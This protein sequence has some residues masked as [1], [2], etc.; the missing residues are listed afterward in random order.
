MQPYNPKLSKKNQGLARVKMLLRAHLYWLN[1]YPVFCDN[2]LMWQCPMS[3]Q[4]SLENIE[5]TAQIVSK[6]QRT[7]NELLKDYSRV[8]PQVVADVTIWSSRCH[9]YLQFFK[10]LNPYKTHGNVVNLFDKSPTYQVKYKNLL[11][12]INTEPKTQ[13]L[14]NAI[15]WLHYIE[16]KSLKKALNFIEK[17][18]TQ[19]NRQNLALKHFVLLSHLYAE[20]GKKAENLQIFL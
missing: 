16:R 3:S 2:K 1:G 8:L 9:E 17:Y 12:R 5:I 14:L 6:S 19:L 7:I 13:E 4:L 11:A 10:E 18:Q 15:S 20:H